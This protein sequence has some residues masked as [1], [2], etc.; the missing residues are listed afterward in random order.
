LR[1]ILITHLH[2]EGLDKLTAFGTVSKLLDRL[3]EVV[4][5][6]YRSQHYFKRKKKSIDKNH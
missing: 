1:L 6:Q 5:S 4:C 3:A 2:P